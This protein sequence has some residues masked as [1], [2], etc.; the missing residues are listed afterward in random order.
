MDIL[1]R[2]SASDH[3]PGSRGKEN[4]DILYGCTGYSTGELCS[5][6][7]VLLTTQVRVRQH[8]ATTSRHFSLWCCVPESD[9][10]HAGQNTNA[11]LG[12]QVEMYVGMRDGEHVSFPI[13][14]LGI[15]SNAGTLVLTLPLHPIQGQDSNSTAPLAVW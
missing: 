8:A 4:R 6:L 15:N 7:L 9:S 5:I 11:C 1:T 2:L 10:N 12:T 3:Q 13:G 14:G